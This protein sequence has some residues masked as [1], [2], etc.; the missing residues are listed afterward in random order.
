M[1]VT[2]ASHSNIQYSWFFL[3]I[4]SCTK[5]GQAV[6][7]QFLTGDIFAK[8]EDCTLSRLDWEICKAAVLVISYFFKVEGDQGLETT[9]LEVKDKRDIAH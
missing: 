2:Y 1:S 6:L 7:E 3:H 8:A 4:L 9:I 5:N